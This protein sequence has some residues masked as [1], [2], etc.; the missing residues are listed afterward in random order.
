MEEFAPINTAE[1]FETRCSERVEAALNEERGKYVDY[2]ALKAAQADWNK[3]KRAMQK[4]LDDYKLAELRRTVAEDKGIPIGMAARL[5]GTTEEELRA[6]ADK[7]LPFLR[8]SYGSPYP[9]YKLQGSSTSGKFASM[10]A[11]LKGD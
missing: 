1:E 8:G 11:A 7:M 9:A 2:D 3:E 4:Q 6:D 10:L 5:T